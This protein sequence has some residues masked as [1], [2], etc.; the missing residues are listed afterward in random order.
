MENISIL[1]RISLIHSYK[2]N[3]TTSTATAIGSFNT[4]SEL[5]GLIVNSQT[6]DFQIVNEKII[7]WQNQNPIVTDS[8]I[9]SILNFK[10]NG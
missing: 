8:D 3:K 5:K 4:L 2:C 10:K 6:N 7:E 9:I 1:R